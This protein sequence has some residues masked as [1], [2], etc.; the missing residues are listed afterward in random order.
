MSDTIIIEALDLNEENTSDIF[1]GCVAR[2]TSKNLTKAVLFPKESGFPEDS[3][4]IYFDTQQVQI[5]KYVIAYMLGQL[6]DIHDGNRKISTKS[7]VYNYKNEPWTTDTS[8]LISFLHLAQAANLISSVNAEDYTINFSPLIE[9]TF[10]KTE[11]NHTTW[12][13][14]YSKK[15][16]KK[17]EGQEPADN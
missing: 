1:L 5:S 12:F 2:N 8:T 9:P 4:P 16:H 3:K 6:K 14:E 10:N 13:K 17:L 7:V 11:P 15:L